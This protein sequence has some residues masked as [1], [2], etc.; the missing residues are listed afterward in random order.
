MKAEEVG[1]QSVKA[2]FR[3]FNFSLL[4]TR[5]AMVTNIASNSSV[6]RHRESSRDLA[7][8]SESSNSSS[9]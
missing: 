4:F 7:T 6:S 3:L 1:R 8:S 2:P 5:L 9:Q